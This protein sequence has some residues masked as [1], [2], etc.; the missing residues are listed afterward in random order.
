MCASKVRCA[1]SVAFAA[2][3]AGLFEVGDDAL[4]GAFGDVAGRGDVAK[5]GDGVADDDEAA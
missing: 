1:P 4:G 2:H 5:T 3:V